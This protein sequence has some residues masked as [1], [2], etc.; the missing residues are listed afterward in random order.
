MRNI[1]VFLIL[2]MLAFSVVWFRDGL[3]R[4]GTPED[5]NDVRRSPML[6]L[7]IIKNNLQADSEDLM[8]RVHKGEI[9]DQQFH[10][11]MSKAA[12]MLLDQGEVKPTKIPAHEAWEYGEIYIT[13]RR[14]KDA[15]TVL[16]TAVKAA[17]GED[18]RVNDNLRLARV[19]A[20]LGDVKSAVSTARSTF[21][22]PDEGSAPILPATLYEII[23]AGEGKGADPE[24]AAL[25]EEA[26]KCEDRTIVNPESV[27]GQSFL[28][29]RPAHDRRAWRK[30]VELYE[31]SGKI[32][33]ARK[34]E[35]R[36][37]A[38]LKRQSGA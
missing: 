15:K 11:Y 22:T 24:L 32:D 8:H 21:N 31:T 19:L 3:T 30:V 20:E 26:I 16:E 14:W 13:A 27:A 6:A 38:A 36:A 33:D 17:K 2:L 9:T 23:P 37:E 18:R 10:E 34:A 28:A 5:P 1:V 35:Q 12:Q 7:S 25:L 4:V 29:A